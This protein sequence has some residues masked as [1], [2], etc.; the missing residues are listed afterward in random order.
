M[1]QALVERFDGE[2]PARMEDLVTSRASAA[3]PATSS[4]ASPSACPGL[5]VDTHVGPAVA[6]ARPH[7]PDRSG[8]GRARAQRDGPAGEARD[9]QPPPDP[10]RPAVC[11][12]RNAPMCRV[13]AQR[14]LPRSSVNSVPLSSTDTGHVTA[15]VS[16]GGVA[17]SGNPVVSKSQ[18][19]S[20]HL[21]PGD[22]GIRRLASP[23]ETAPSGAVA[24]FGHA[25]QRAAQRSSARVA[26]SSRRRRVATARARRLRAHAST[27]SPRGRR[28][29][30]R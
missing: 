25:A 28:S 19:G 30:A 5:P 13:R 14:L 26:T 27:S 7:D 4:A 8:Q 17:G 10:P 6:P 2:V 21:V 1:A 12:A 11:I 23:R 15:R 16:R 18:P 9:V 22:A 24:H 3:R 29:T 20:R